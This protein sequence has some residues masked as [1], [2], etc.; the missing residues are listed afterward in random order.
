MA[1]V[2]YELRV[3][4]GGLIRVNASGGSLEGQ[5]QTGAQEPNNVYTFEPDTGFGGHFVL[6]GSG[7]LDGQRA[8]VAL[9]VDKDNAKVFIQVAFPAGI[10]KNVDSGV[11]IFRLDADGKCA[12]GQRLT[13]SVELT[14]EY[15]GRTTLTDSHC[16][17]TDST[18]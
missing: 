18:P 2:L 15:L 8:G 4:P 6:V 7:R 9:S 10:Q 14:L 16:T 12:S 13:T 17:A 11:P 1:A 3:L 5:Y